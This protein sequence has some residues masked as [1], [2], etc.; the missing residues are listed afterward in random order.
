[1][2]TRLQDRLKETAEGAQWFELLRARDA[3][4]DAPDLV[5]RYE[6]TYAHLVSSGLLFKASQY[7][8]IYEV[9]WDKLAQLQLPTAAR[10]LDGETP[11]ARFVADSLN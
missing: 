10:S 1:M 2:L 7:V 6:Q 8:P 4:K 9:D 11:P 5:A 3:A